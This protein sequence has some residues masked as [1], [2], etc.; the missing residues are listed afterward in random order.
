M[1]TCAP[2][3]AELVVFTAMVLSPHHDGE[4]PTLLSSSAA[5]P[6]VSGGQDHH[7]HTHALNLFPD[8]HHPAQILRICYSEPHSAPK[9][10]HTSLAL[11]LLNQ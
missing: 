5:S 2:W 10:P 8:S 11:S 7:C 4:T 1:P 9:H 3:A 6:V